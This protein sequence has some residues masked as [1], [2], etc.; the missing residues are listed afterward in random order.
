MVN[1]VELL[2]AHVVELKTHFHFT[3]MNNMMGTLVEELRHLT[4]LKGIHVQHNRGLTGSIPSRYGELEH[5][6][7]LALM[8]NSL[9]GTLP[10][11][12]GRLSKLEKLLLEFNELSG[13]TTKGDLDW[14]RDLRL[15]VNLSLEHN[16][17]FTGTI[18]DFIGNNRGNQI[19]GYVG[20]A[21]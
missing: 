19:Y 13:D 8:H 9:N 7:I 20:T 14:L 17:G 16:A 11:E 6:Q 4:Y 1:V 2:G 21:I 12:L 3:A 10:P 18:P 15:L 5:L